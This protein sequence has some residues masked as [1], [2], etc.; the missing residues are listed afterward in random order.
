MAGHP[1]SDAFS[2]ALHRHVVAWLCEDPSSV[3]ARAE[4]RLRELRGMLAGGHADA[5]LDRWEDLLAEGP[6]AVVEVLQ[7]DDPDAR[8]LRGCSPFAGS[9]APGERWRILRELRDAS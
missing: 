8:Q 7:S 5:L 9:I 6:E 1:R 4:D 3:M 2:D